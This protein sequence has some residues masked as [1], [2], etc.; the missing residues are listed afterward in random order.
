M[1]SLSLTPQYLTSLHVYDVE[2]RV[3]LV[4]FSSFN[5]KFVICIFFFTIIEEEKR[6]QSYMT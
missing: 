2:P 5:S 1:L 4:V 6:N 3:H